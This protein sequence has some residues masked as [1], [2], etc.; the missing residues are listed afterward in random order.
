MLNKIIEKVENKNIAILGFSKEGK[1]TYNFIKRHNIKANITILD[2]NEKIL[3][4]NP[5]LKEENVKL[6]LGEK[7]LDDL[8]RFDLIFKS[9]GVKL[10]DINIE[11]FKDKITSNLGIVLDTYKNNLIIITGTKGKSTTTSLIYKVLKDQN[12][13]VYLTGNIGIPI[14]DEIDNINENTLYI[15]EASS[16]Q[17]EFI[18]TSP[19][20]A[21][22]LNLFEEHLDFYKSKED[23]FLAKMNNFKYQDKSD[24]AIYTSENETLK[25][26]VLKGMYKSKLID[27]NEVITRKRNN[28][29]LNNKKIYNKKDK[30]LLLGE[31]NL[32]DIEFVLVLADI[33]KLDRKKLVNSI[34]TFKPLEH[35]LEL[36]GTIKKVTYYND[37]ISTIPQTTISAIE[38]LKKVDTLIFG[39]MDRGI[40]Y[41][42]LITYLNKSKIRNF[43]CMPTT[44]YNIG[45]KLNKKN[46]Y[47][48]E[49]LKEAVKLA[50]KITKK[51]KI[52]LLSP[53]ASSYE[54]FKNFE[55]KGLKY[56]EYV[57]EEND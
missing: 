2:G 43:I 24:Y 47:F 38:T 5:Y 9:P 51:G 18:K 15:F 48:I 11:S 7:Y 42:S 8:N 19:H 40:D 3:E 22:I 52:C 55:E 57:Q 4:N 39:G 10:K 6:V 16:H 45:K 35:R 49:D 56:K 23:Y 12:Y 54:Y 37:S 44:G 32:K 25:A 26:Y 36:V 53:A 33:L 34:N 14:L 29:Y 46:I 41:T 30:R 50:K 28:L 31:H 17:L 27:V 21:L 1:S 13:D 20:I